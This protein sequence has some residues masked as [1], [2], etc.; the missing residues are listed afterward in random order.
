MFKRKVISWVTVVSLLVSILLVSFVQPIA[1][2][3]GTTKITIHYQEAKGNTKDWS[4]WVWPEGGEGKAYS[5]TGQDA[6]GKTA[7]IELP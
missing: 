5:F 1:E 6:F 4:L 3:S 2:A 7:E